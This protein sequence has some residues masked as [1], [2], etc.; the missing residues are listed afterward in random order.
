MPVPKKRS[1]NGLKEKM[2][3]KNKSIKSIS[4]GKPTRGKNRGNIKS[5]HSLS[6]KEILGSISNTKT[7]SKRMEP[8]ASSSRRGRPRKSPIPSGSGSGSDSERTSAPHLSTS[9]SQSSSKERT[10]RSKGGLDPNETSEIMID[11]KPAH[12]QQVIMYSL[13]GCPYCEKAKKLLINFKIPFNDFMAKTNDIETKMKYKEL[14]ESDTLPMI[15]IKNCDDPA[16]YAQIGG[17][18]DLVRYIM[19]LQEL[20]ESDVDIVA[21]KGLHDI[22][23]TPRNPNPNPVPIPGVT[24]S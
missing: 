24:S 12:L 2:D 6:I 7:T 1:P 16:K 23:S 18:T 5:F 17:Y 21:L 22:L 20:Q 19:T 8:N 13:E 9:Q 11:G 10:G 14:T 15:Y 3:K 4:T